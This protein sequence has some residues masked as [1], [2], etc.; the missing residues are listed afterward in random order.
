MLYRLRCFADPVV[1]LVLEL[2]GQLARAALG[3]DAVD[4]H[5]DVVGL[6]VVEDALVV[7]DLEDPGALLV[8]QRVDPV[9]DVA[10]GR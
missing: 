6:D 3:D 8:A 9:R 10:D 2:F 7:G 1:A 5:V 4:H